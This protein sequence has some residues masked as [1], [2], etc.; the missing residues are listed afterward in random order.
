MYSHHS[1]D[2]SIKDGEII[3]DEGEALALYSGGGDKNL[4][5]NTSSATTST[6][7]GK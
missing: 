6:S 1:D 2:S 7:S 5:E 4:R 3:A